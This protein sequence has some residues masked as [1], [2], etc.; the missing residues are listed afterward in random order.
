M[1]QVIEMISWRMKIICM[2]ISIITGNIVKQYQRQLCWFTLMSFESAINEKQKVENYRHNELRQVC[3]HN[4]F[5]HTFFFRSTNSS[6]YTLHN[7]KRKSADDLTSNASSS[8][9][10]DEIQ[11]LKDVKTAVKGFLDINYVHLCKHQFF[12]PQSWQGEVSLQH[13][14]TTW[15]HLALLC[16]VDPCCLSWDKVL[17]D[18]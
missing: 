14:G 11:I 1:C 15:I 2:Q 5:S 13:V 4:S 3:V 8:D 17:N 6:T 12:R 10:I 7:D 18:R 9:T 16:Q